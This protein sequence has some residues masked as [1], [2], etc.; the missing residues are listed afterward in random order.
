ML[1]QAFFDILL[2]VTCAYA[3]MRGG[4]P[5]RITGMTLL[6]ADFL[7]ILTASAFPQRFRQVEIGIFLVDLSVLLIL[8]SVAMRSTR[9]WPLFLAGFQLDAVAVHAMRLAAPATLPV[10]YMNA[11]ALWAYPMQIILAAGAWRHRRRLQE[12]RNDPP[13][14]PRKR[15][16]RPA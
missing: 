6:L 7:T 5:E 15:G 13:W 8:V 14:V 4:S 2:V 10:A 1:R 12:H 16:S 9:W 11:I 3:L